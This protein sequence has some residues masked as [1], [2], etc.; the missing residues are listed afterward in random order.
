MGYVKFKLH[1]M[2][3]RT[4]IVGYVMFRSLH[5][6]PIIIELRS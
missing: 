5:I 3:G 6:K 2:D 1:P 4:S